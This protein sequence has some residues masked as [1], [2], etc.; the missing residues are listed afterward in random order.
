[1]KV[2]AVAIGGDLYEHARVTRDTANFLRSEFQRASP[3]PIIVAPGNHDPLVPSSLYKQV[4]WPTN[5]FIFQT[6]VLSRYSAAEGIS[7]WGAAHD[8]PSFRANLL[9]HFRVPRNGMNLLLLHAS[10]ISHLPEGKEAHC[11]FVPEEIGEA[12]IDFAMLGHYHTASLRPEED[13]VYC[14]PGSPEPLGF[15]ERGEHCV[16]LLEVDGSRISKSL[17]P[18]NE[19]V[20]RT[21]DVDVTDAHSIEDVV[22]AVKSIGREQD[23][24]S[25]FIRIQLVGPLSPDVDLDLDRVMEAC[26]ED[27]AFLDVRNLTYP[28]YDYEVLRMDQTVRGAFVRRMLDLIERAAT[29]EEKGTLQN[30]LIY[31]LQAFDQREII[32]R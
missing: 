29:E 19:T 16:L 27:Y 11:P 26:H 24:R 9:K 7:I 20:Y 12:G 14:Y 17:I 25:C 5:V 32:P 1:M 30:G 28:A 4:E 22:Q 3:V 23:A 18:V 8:S 15:G 31:G 13:P 2:N 6:T 21:V 10:D